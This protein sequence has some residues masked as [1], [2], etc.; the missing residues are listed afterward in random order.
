MQQFF[1]I[2]LITFSLVFTAENTFSQ[3]DNEPDKCFD[4]R[5]KWRLLDLDTEPLEN[6]NKYP[7][8]VAPTV[9]A[10]KGTVEPP[11]FNINAEFDREPF[12]ATSKEYKVDRRGDVKTDKSGKPVYEEK[13]REKGRPKLEWLEQNKLNTKY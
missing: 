6:P 9:H 2:F 7:G 4:H 3:E 5:A 1:R 10:A 13:I 12:T 8:L 11:K